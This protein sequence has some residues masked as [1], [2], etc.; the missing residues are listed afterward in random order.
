MKVA[1]LVTWGKPPARARRT[2]TAKTSKH[3]CPNTIDPV[4]QAA[5]NVTCHGADN[6]AYAP[7]LKARRVAA[8]D[9]VSRRLQI[10]Q[11]T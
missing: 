3:C 6:G 4:L 11:G 9:C 10:I 1:S 7:C 2:S 5:W 8:M